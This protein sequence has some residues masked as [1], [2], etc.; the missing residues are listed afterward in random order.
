MLDTD[1]HDLARRSTSERVEDGGRETTD[2]LDSVVL[3][4][5]ADNRKRRR[6]PVIERESTVN[7]D[8]DVEFG[9]CLRKQFSILDASPSDL[10]D[11]PCLM[12]NQVRN[13]LPWKTLVNK[14]AHWP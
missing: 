4:C 8:E 10:L 13:K 3:G 14:D 9:G 2:G 1:F 7:R 5:K 12:P 6:W 11:S